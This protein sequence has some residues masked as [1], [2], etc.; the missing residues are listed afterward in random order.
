MVQAVQAAIPLEPDTGAPA[1]RPVGPLSGVP[2]LMLCGL[3]DPY[4][5]CGE[6]W[7]FRPADVSGANYTFSGVPDCAHGM[8]T[9]G[10]GSC[11]TGDDAAAVMHQI[12]AHI[13]SANASTSNSDGA[14]AGDGTSAGAAL[15]GKFLLLQLLTIAALA[16]A[17]M[18]IR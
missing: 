3:K 18:S 11:A 16:V 2:T 4:L 10:P 12:T 1:S 9:V 15:A 8:L 13:L 5:L 6:P 14:G 17:V 7:A